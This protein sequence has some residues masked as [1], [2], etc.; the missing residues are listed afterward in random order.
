MN[1]AGDCWKHTQKKGKKLRV[2]IARL[3]EGAV[4]WI[5]YYRGDSFQV[6]FEARKRIGQ[7]AI[8][9]SLAPNGK[10]YGVYACRWYRM[11]GR[12]SIKDFRLKHP[13]RDILL[14]FSPSSQWSLHD[15]TSLTCHTVLKTFTERGPHI[16]SKR[17]W[18]VQSVSLPHHILRTKLLGDLWLRLG[19]F[20]D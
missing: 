4:W 13:R 2:R 14:F 16:R 15:D 7:I 10:K 19:I 3:Q 8:G 9:N 12:E 1:H 11:N 20:F 6:E 17:A 5:K 18:T